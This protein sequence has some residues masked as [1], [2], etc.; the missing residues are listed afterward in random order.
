MIQY[1]H[2]LLTGGVPALPSTDRLPRLAQSAAVHQL[3]WP[4]VLG[5]ILGFAHNLITE[6]EVISYRYFMFINFNFPLFINLFIDL[7]FDDFI[8][9]YF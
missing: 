1:L 7:N 2:E 5:K 4:D 9:Y 6:V 3:Q 8:D